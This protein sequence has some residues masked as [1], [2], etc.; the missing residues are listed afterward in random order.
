MGHS[1]IDLGEVPASREQSAPPLMPR[2]PVPYRALLGALSVV[3]VAV[4]AGSEFR[5][6]PRPPTVIPAR[7]GDATYVVGDR[8]F[9]VGAGRLE[10]DGETVVNRVIST[11]A[12]PR[13]DLVTRTTVAVPGAVI[14]VL[15]ARSTLLVGYQMNSSGTG[16]VT[17]TSA[18]DGRRL[19]QR[20]ARL[21]AA[22]AADGIALLSDDHGEFAVDLA[23][24]ALRWSVPRP[25]DGY[26]TE[27]GPDGTYVRWLVLVTDSGRLE[28]RDARTGRLLARRTLSAQTGR[29]N[30]LIWP[31]GDLILV[32]T[33]GA[34]FDG[35]RLPALDRVWRTTVDLSQSWMQAD[36][37]VAICTYRQQRGMTALDPATGRE[38]WDSDRWAYAE[39]AGKYLLATAN[40]GEADV[41][42]VWVLDPASGRVLGNFGNWQ[43]IGGTSGDGVVYGK[44]DIRGSYQMWYGVLDP[45]T[46]RVRI[47]GSADR[48]SGGCETGAKALICRL[49][50]ASVAVWRL[51]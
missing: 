22:S 26:I 6:P 9:V 20:T 17:A 37:G 31:T 18:A 33:G 7:L 32:D 11:Y 38:L 16:G 25:A 40:D 45:A 12:L 34:G 15:L 41:P 4:L 51:G 19:W 30:G 14:Q 8:L 39:P 29:A 44:L 49:V 23:T 1:V 48:V 43:G 46:R 13:A 10:N 24:G 5:P 50:D 21:V 28:T 2:P 35:Y 27:A 47:L 3:L 42:Q 36:C